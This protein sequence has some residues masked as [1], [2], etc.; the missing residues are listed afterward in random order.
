MSETKNLP[1][2]ADLYKDVALAKSSDTL[3]ALLNQ[4]PSEKWVKVH[5]FI[6]G[7]K[8]LPIDKVEF[9][10]KSIFKQYRIEIIR[11]G[12]AFNGVYVVVRVHYCNPV[13]GEWDYHDG[14]GAKELQ[15]KKGASAADLSSINN[16]ALA[17]AFPIAKTVALKDACDHFGK[18]FG[19]DL[20]RK[21]VM[22]IKQDS[23]LQSMDVIEKINNTVNNTPA[24]PSK[25][26]DFE[27]VDE[28]HVS[29][30]A[31]PVQVVD[32]ETP[33]AQEN[34]SVIDDDDDF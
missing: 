29:Q 12:V 30:Q 27:V 6:A 34:N 4:N 33:P 26:Q 25:Y 3:T 20:N 24:E 16:G 11:E 9:L 10:L 8:Y 28:I 18:L 23:Y 14:I 31:E 5:P 15:V 22:D 17:M 32:E 13:T 21:D 2:I 19:S 1:K 7:Y